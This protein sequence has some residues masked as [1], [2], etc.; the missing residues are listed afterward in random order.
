VEMLGQIKIGNVTEEILDYLWALR[1]PLTDIGGIKPTR[2]Y[3]HRAN[4]QHENEMEF[5]KL[6]QKEYV[7]EAIDSGTISTS[8]THTRQLVG[9]ELDNYFFTNLQSYKT[10]RLKE[11]AQVMLLKNVDASS[12]L[13]NGSRGVVV[14]FQQY[15]LEEL[16]ATATEN[17][18]R[19]FLTYFR[20]HCDKEKQKVTLPCVRYLSS[21]GEPMITRTVLPSSWTQT[22]Y[23]SKGKQTLERVQLPL[24]LACKSPS[25]ASYFPSI[26]DPIKQGP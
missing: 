15:G 10:L 18:R 3:T 22:S 16:L 26:A 25:F 1:R 11:G 2:L 23:L 14:G 6:K 20:Q 24:A 5:R 8:P 9:S 17:D 4:V 19:V 7:I 13:A 12:K 21:S